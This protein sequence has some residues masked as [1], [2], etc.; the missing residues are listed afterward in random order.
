M[1]KILNIIGP[2]DGVINIQHAQEQYA[3]RHDGHM[4]IDPVGNLM[5]NRFYLQKPR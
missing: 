2:P 4:F 3:P 1:Q 5:M